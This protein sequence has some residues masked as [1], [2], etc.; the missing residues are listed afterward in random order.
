[1]KV[2][3]KNGDLLSVCST[4]MEAYSEFPDG[5]YMDGYLTDDKGEVIAEGVKTAVT[6]EPTNSEDVNNLRFNETANIVVTI[7][8]GISFNGD[9][10][11]QTRLSRAITV[12]ATDDDKTTWIDV[13][14]VP[15]EVTKA[16]LKEALKL[17]GEAQTALWVKYATLKAELA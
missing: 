14:G 5:T 13:D 11:S 17:A 8:S 12:L 6:F 7:G 15:H 16:D 2:L 10:T 1:M 9:E 4:V 3:D